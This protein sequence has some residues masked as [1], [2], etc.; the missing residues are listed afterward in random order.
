[1]RYV[2]AAILLCVLPGCKKGFGSNFEGQITMR[3]T[4]AGNPPSDMLVKAKGDRLRFDTTENGQTVSAIFDP[5][6]NTVVAL[7]D[8]Q[9]AYMDMDFSSPS[10]APN[11]DPKT[12]GA[13]KTGKKETIAGIDCEDYVVKDPSG[14]K[15]EVCIA[16]GLAFFDLEGVRHGGGA[17]WNKDLRDKKMFPLR[18]IEYDETGKEV[19]R[20]EVTK[21][22]PKKL[23]DALFQVPK[24]Y[25]K[26][27]TPHHT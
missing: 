20:S 21:V 11:T 1:M 8:A 17:G 6:K 25:T 12:S 10:A 27:P 13:E 5:Q 22:E 24:D 4:R 18:S 23:D 7:M 19:S 9:R 3:T 2:L 26:V 14:K 16:E 15:T